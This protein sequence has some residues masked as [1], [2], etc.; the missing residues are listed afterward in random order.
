MGT[1]TTRT[2]SDAISAKSSSLGVTVGV[3]TCVILLFGCACVGAFVVFM[4]QRPSS[5]GNRSQGASPVDIPS[6]EERNGDFVWDVDGMDSE[7]PSRGRRR[8]PLPSL[9]SSAASE[10][11]F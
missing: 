2:V 1:T 8:E 10:G 5:D 11:Y 6:A 4:R 9:L 7:D 3:V